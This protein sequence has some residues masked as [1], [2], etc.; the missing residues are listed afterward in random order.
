MARSAARWVVLGTSL[1]HSF[2]IAGTVFGWP[3]VA[4]MLQREGQ[5]DELCTDTPPGM[6]GR[7]KQSSHSPGLTEAINRSAT[8]FHTDR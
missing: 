2:L 1:V 6:V 3:S 8:L 5:Y 4:V 7:Q